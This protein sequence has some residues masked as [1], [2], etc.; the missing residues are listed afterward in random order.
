[1]AAGKMGNQHALGVI[2][3]PILLPYGAQFHF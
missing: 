1:M 2:A 3:P